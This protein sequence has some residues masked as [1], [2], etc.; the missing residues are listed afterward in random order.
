MKKLK[1]F[2]GEN[3]AITVVT[4]FDNDTVIQPKSFAI[5]ETEATFNS[6][7]FYV[8]QEGKWLGKINGS[9]GA[10]LEIYLYSNNVSKSYFEINCD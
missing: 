7:N 4:N 9:T 3:V 6:D 5:I 2:N 8:E 10:D 1:V